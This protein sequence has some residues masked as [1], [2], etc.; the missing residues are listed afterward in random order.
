M[1]IIY[2]FLI[3]ILFSCTKN[4]EEDDYKI[5]NTVLKDKV[6]TYGIILNHLHWPN[7]YSRKE[8]D[9]IL[10]KISDSLYKTQSLKYYLDSQLSIL[11]TLNPSDEFNLSPILVESRKT[12]SDCKLDFSKITEPKFA[13]RLDKSLP[14]DNNEK[15]PTYLGDYELSEPVYISKNKA[16]IRYQH[17][18]GS[19]CGLG[20]LIYLKKENGVWKIIKEE[21]IWIS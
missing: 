8:I 11:D 13:K 15:K 14:I 4:T 12:I 5:Y 17:Y 16:V 19:K 1:R 21:Q 10:P 6:S 2:F 18:C 9:S 20:L 7:N 3:L